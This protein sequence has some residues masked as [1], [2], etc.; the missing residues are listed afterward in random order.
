MD[1]YKAA[2]KDIDAFVEHR[3]EFIT[4]IRTLNNVEDFRNQTK[5]YIK[6]HIDKDD[7]IIFIASDRQKIVSS[8]MACIFQTLPL[9]SCI[10]GKHAE[11]LNVY[12]LESY[13]GQGFATKIIG[14]LLNELKKNDIEKVI[15]NY[16]D[17][18]LPLYHKL[19]FIELDHQMQL[20][21]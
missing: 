10:T 5:A 3:I 7:L 11:L 8:C 12:T 2:Q 15:L 19:G 14:M 20:K 13:R 6:E 16:T 17:M 4:S 9:P 21:L 18:A 1:F